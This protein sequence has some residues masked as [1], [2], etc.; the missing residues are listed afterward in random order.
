ML[1]L[2]I[3]PEKVLVLLSDVRSVTV[4]MSVNQSSSSVVS[5]LVN[6]EYLV[7]LMLQILSV[8]E[9][10]IECLYNVLILPQGV[11]VVLMGAD[12]QSL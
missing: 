2:L 10:N 5:C 9:Q 8:F 3:S 12:G 11:Q 1:N 4:S 7:A 6:M